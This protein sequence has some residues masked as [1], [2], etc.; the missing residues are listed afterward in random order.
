MS[1]PGARIPCGLTSA[2]LPIGDG[3]LPP[4]CPKCGLAGKLDALCIEGIE[5]WKMVLVIKIASPREGL[6][7]KW[8]EMPGDA[9]GLS[10]TEK[11]VNR[12]SDN[13]RSNN[14]RTVGQ[15]LL[16]PAIHTF[17]VTNSATQESTR[18]DRLT[19]MKTFPSS[20]KVHVTFLPVPICRIAHCEK[21]SQFSIGREGGWRTFCNMKQFVFLKLLFWDLIFYSS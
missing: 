6:K 5:K 12:R 7:W 19:R 11:S 18:V 21:Y 2:D 8:W 14:W 13:W 15:Y 4:S 17:P 10:R 20:R 16:K 1:Y 3:S 9:L